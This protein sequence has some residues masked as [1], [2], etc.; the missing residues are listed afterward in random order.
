VTGADRQD[1][2]RV[3]D[4]AYT[5]LAAPEDVQVT[6]AT[7]GNVF[8]DAALSAAPGV[9]LTITDHVPT[10]LA[11]VD[12]L[13]VD[14]LPAPSPP[15]VPMLAIA[16]TVW[17]DGVTADPPVELPALTFQDTD[18]ELLSDV[19]L[20]EVGVASATPLS[21]AALAPL[22]GGP[23]GDLLLAGRLDGRPVVLLGFDLL[24]SNLP[25]TATWPVFVANTVSWL[26]G[27]PATVSVTAGTD[28]TLPT[29]IGAKAIQVSPPSGAP[30][31]VD[32]ASPRVIVDQ[33]G[34][35]RL[36]YT[37]DDVAA[38][39][40]ALAVNPVPAEGDLSRP[41]PDPVVPGGPDAGTD[42]VTQGRQPIGR[43]ILMAV[44]ALAVLEWLWVY[45]VR[46]WRRRR[47][48]HAERPATRVGGA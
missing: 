36:A 11:G 25:L 22:A 28:V 5:L 9:D 34:L 8:L 43:Q 13:V 33:V 38:A 16:A 2:L 44:L 21:A 32:P 45:G 42:G 37:G 15:P 46:P 30:F 14:R 20:S 26:A 39:P 7:P 3:D 1:A 31:T 19:D 4:A 23:S 29:P 35:W 12:L 27:P 24:R 18:H 17:P 41:A 6:L 40:A 48:E 47:R 10:D